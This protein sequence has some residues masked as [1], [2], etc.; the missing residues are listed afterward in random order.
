MSHHDKRRPQAI[1]VAYPGKSQKFAR[2]HQDMTTTYGICA[3]HAVNI[4]A[5][6]LIYYFPLFIFLNENY[7]VSQALSDRA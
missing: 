5:Y 7:L 4:I 2:I 6:M 1:L 3:H